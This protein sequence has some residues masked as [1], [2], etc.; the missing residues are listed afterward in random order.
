MSDCSFNNNDTGRSTS[1]Y[2][3]RK[4]ELSIYYDVQKKVNNG[5]TDYVNS[6]YDYI[7]VDPTLNSRIYVNGHRMFNIF[8]KGTTN[9]F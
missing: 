9:T 4:K 2:I 7:R 8:N 1:E 6:T 3:R 5:L